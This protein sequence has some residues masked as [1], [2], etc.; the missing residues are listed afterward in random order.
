MNNTN[1]RITHETGSDE[2]W[3]CICKNTPDAEGFFPC[4]K[5]GNQMEPEAGWEDLYVCAKCG[6]IINQ[7]TLEVV[8][9]NPNPKFQ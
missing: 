3:V 2:A 7:K 1:E 4:D 9:R 5:E 6:R 8:A